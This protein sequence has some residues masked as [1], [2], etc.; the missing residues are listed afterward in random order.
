VAE[1]QGCS[2]VT[3]ILVVVSEFM[4]MEAGGNHNLQAVVLN[5]GFLSPPWLSEVLQ[6]G[7]DWKGKRTSSQNLFR[8]Y[9]FLKS[10]SC[11]VLATLKANEVFKSR[12]GNECSW[13]F[14]T[15]KCLQR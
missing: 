9:A 5:L 11:K 6:G 15:V 13:K 7:A 2:V 4:R 12:F 1:G 3:Q 8:N 10:S 14:L